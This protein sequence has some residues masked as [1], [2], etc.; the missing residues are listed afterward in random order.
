MARATNKI[1]QTQTSELIDNPAGYH[2]NVVQ[3]RQRSMWPEETDADHAITR[4][5]RSPSPR[6][7]VGRRGETASSLRR[8]RASTRSKATA[9]PATAST[10]SSMN[11][12]F[13][14]AP[15]VG[16]GGHQDDQGIRRADQR[17]RRK[18]H[19][20]LSQGELRQ[21]SRSSP[22]A[23]FESALSCPIFSPRSQDAADIRAVRGRQTFGVDNGLQGRGGRGHGQCGPRNAQ[24]SGRAPFPGRRGGRA[25][26]APQP[27][28][29]SLVRRQDAQG[30][31][32]RASTTSPTST[33]A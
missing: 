23:A 31:S 9:P 14:N 10:T 26:F 4:H 7:L 18:G 19:R 22:A 16:R 5:C 6:R 1:G 20:R 32:A 25:R 21:L 29:R 33:S 2:H 30:Q 12:P 13:P 24:H 3:Q 28:H 8:R 11:S 17:C 27:G 15:G